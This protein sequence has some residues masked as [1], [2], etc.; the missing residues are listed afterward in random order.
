MHTTV[1]DNFQYI[2][3]MRWC[4]FTVLPILVNAE[5]I[6]FEN[7]RVSLFDVVLWKC[8][9]IYFSLHIIQKTFLSTKIIDCLFDLLRN[10]F[11]D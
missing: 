8:D 3:I 5:K 6:T 11:R 10:T 4:V 7:Q 1:N 2:Y 9:D